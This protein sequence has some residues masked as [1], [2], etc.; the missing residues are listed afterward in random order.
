MLPRRVILGLAGAAAALRAQHTPPPPESADTDGRRGAAGIRLPNGQLQSDAIARLEYQN[1]LDDARKLAK[2]ADDL[3][4][5][6]EKND[7]F[8][9]SMSAIKKT[10]DIEKLAKRIRARMKHY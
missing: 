5:E 8:V 3:S 1:T 2:M 9:I 6:I 4:A 10:E 7:R